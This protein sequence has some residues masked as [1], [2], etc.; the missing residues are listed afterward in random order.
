MSLRIL[1]RQLPDRIGRRKVLLAGVVSMFFGMLT[2]TLVTADNPY[3]IVIPAFLCGSGH[4]LIYHSMTSII[5]SEFAPSERGSGT[6]L[7][8]MTFDGGHILMSWILGIIAK[9]VSYD[10]MFLT[11]AGVL[12]A[13][14]VLYFGRNGIR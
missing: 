5:L 9:Q 2:Y 12:A 13:V 10:A 6:A 14:S 7:A 1:T 11:V 4:A 8:T 3:L